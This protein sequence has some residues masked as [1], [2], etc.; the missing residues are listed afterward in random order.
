MCKVLDIPR[1]LVYYKKKTRVYNTKL[2]N[3][4][5]SIFRESKNNYGSR[6]IKIELKKT[7]HN[8]IKKKD[9]TNYGQ[10]QIGF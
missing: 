10:V 4:V 8:S 7:K 3:A 9:K 2:E 6:K 5:I 1:S